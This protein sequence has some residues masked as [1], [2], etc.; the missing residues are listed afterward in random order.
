MPKIKTSRTKAPPEGF[1]ELEE[2][3]SISSHESRSLHIQSYCLLLLLPDGLAYYHL[4]L[5]AR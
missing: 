5:T 1:D 4:D 3:V 2:V